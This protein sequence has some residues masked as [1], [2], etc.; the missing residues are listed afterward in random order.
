V[1]C[2]LILFETEAPQPTPEVHDCGLN[3]S[4]QS[5]AALNNVSRACANGPMADEVK[6]A[7]AA[8]NPAIPQGCRAASVIAG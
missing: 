4:P 6:S 7:A 8:G 1:E 3:V 2:G 5:S